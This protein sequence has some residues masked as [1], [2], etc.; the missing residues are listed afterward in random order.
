MLN[1]HLAGRR[2]TYEVAAL[3]ALGVRRRTLLLSLVA[4]QGLLLLFGIGVGVAAGLVG[5]LLALPD[6]PEFADTPVTPP[7]LYGVHA[8]PLVVTIGVVVVLLAAVIALG[9]ANLLRS[10]RYEQL[11]EAPA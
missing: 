5:A 6:V 1:L 11:R 3:S 9:S 10:A 7:Q 2:R 8:G 4:E